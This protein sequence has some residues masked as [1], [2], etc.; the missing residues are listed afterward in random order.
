MTVVNMSFWLFDKSSFSYNWTFI[1]F[2]FK[3]KLWNCSELIKSFSWIKVAVSIECESINSR[4]RRKLLIFGF[5][6]GPTSIQ[7][8]NKRTARHV[9]AWALRFDELPKDA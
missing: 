9:P 6:F 5:K 7:T 8:D 4:W 2:D 1:L 3:L